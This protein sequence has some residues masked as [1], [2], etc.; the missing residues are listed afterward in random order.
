MKLLLCIILAP[1]PS[2]IWLVFYLRKDKH[3]EP[4]KMVVKIFFF[5]AI[6]IT[7]AA[8]LEQG[9]FEGLKAI[10]LSEKIL[11]L[12]IGFALIEELLKYLVIKFGVL[13]NPN[14][15][16]PIDSMIYLI[17]AALGFA[18]AENIYLLSQISPLKIP[19]GETIEFIT[20]RFLGATF[21]HALAS[22]V[23]G[24][25][26]AASLC[27]KSRFRKTLIFGG[28][29]AA[30]ILHSVFNYIIIFNIDGHIETYQ[31]NILIF[32]LLFGAA[33]IVSLMFKKINKFRS[34]CKL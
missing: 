33:V 10:S 4:N 27:T 26:L 12:V 32:V 29:V 23:M 14:F 24:Y 13:K 18:A 22:A 9:L 30:T 34:V 2:I 28:L 21:L 25:F 16:E 5:G 15:D 11:L 17:I 3:P 1:L 20:T 8:L 19:I 7:L 6:M 31:R